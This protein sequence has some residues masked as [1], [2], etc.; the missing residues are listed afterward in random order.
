MRPC[1]R[2]KLLGGPYAA[3]P[4]EAHESAQPWR[5]S[6]RPWWRKGTTLLLPA[7]VSVKV[8]CDHLGPTRVTLTLD[9]YCHVLATMRPTCWGAIPGK[10]PRMAVQG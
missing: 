8:V 1:D 7:D 6:R 9:T 4:V 3:L 2:V 10:N 5:R